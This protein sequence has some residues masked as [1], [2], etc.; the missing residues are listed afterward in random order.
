MKGLSVAD[1]FGRNM[2]DSAAIRITIGI[3]P[4]RRAKGMRQAFDKDQWQSYYSTAADWLQ[5]WARDYDPNETITRQSLL[6]GKK[7]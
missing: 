2:A 4:V 3:I 7:Q 6:L 1:Y 5:S